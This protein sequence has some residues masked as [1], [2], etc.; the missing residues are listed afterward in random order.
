MLT[1]GGG[2]DHFG[3][4]RWFYNEEREA[5]LSRGS[6]MDVFTAIQYICIKRGVVSF[7]CSLHVCDEQS[8]NLVL[9]WTRYG[10][11]HSPYFYSFKPEMIEASNQREKAT[12]L[13]QRFAH[14]D[15]LPLPHTTCSLHTVDHTHITTHTNKTHNTTPSRKTP[16][17]PD[18][19]CAATS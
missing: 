13:H 4:F 9:I 12:T 5:A 16:S 8:T 17:E 10:V 14:A 2:K 1:S 15:T 18:N 11:V 19:A 6:K 7:V 3:I